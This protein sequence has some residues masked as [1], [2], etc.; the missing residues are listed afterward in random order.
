MPLKNE[1][2]TNYLAADPLVE[3]ATKPFPLGIDFKTDVMYADTLADFDSSTSVASPS[4]SRP[5]FL[6][7]SDVAENCGISNKGRLPVKAIAP[8]R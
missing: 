6:L 4:S 8:N 7:V 1:K 2:Q 5:R 3:D